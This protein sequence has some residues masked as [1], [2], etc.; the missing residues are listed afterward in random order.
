MEMGMQ[1][2]RTVELTREQAMFVEA[3]RRLGAAVGLRD[4]AR[5]INQAHA[6]YREQ[7]HQKGKKALKQMGPWLAIF[8]HF[9]TA[10]GNAAQQEERAGGELLH[11]ALEAVNPTPRSKA[12]EAG[13]A[14]ARKL[15][16][17]LVGKKKPCG[18]N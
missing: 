4:A 11:R 5:H 15:V 14:L 7:L 12:E 1:G 2:T 18:C 10:L 3:G 16:G 9:A 8:D 17:K 6:A 13:G